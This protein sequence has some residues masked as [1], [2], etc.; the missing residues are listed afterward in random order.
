MLLFWIVLGM[1]LGA[2]FMVLTRARSQDGDL[3]LAL[4][5]VVAAL[6][7][8]GFALLGRASLV[9]AFIEGMGVAGYGLLA[10][11]GVR[12]SRWWLVAGWGLHPVWD[13]WLHLVEQGAHFTPVWYVWACL[14]FDLV[15]AMYLGLRIFQHERA[16]ARTRFRYWRSPNRDGVRDH[17]A[18]P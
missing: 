2:F 8:V 9:W 3:I 17:L 4:G 13:V 5:L 1:V 7:Y 11:C 15:V 12:F 18:T 10:W 14:G 16:T 6:I